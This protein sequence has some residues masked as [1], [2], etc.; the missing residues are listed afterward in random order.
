[1]KKLFIATALAAASLAAQ[2]KDIALRN[3][4]LMA[5]QTSDFLQPGATV[6][7]LF[8]AA[9]NMVGN[10]HIGGNPAPLTQ[11]TAVAVA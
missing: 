7:L 2:A 5:E 4:H 6:P 1:M 11:A 8:V 10:D 9:N 3:V